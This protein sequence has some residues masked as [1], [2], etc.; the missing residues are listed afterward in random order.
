MN[1]KKRAVK[2][3]GRQLR[4]LVNEAVGDAEEDRAL[5]AA[6]ALVDALRDL[7]DSEHFQSAEQ[8]ASSMKRSYGRRSW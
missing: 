3:T 1:S 4:R 6:D 8:L 2:L 7:G 5:Q